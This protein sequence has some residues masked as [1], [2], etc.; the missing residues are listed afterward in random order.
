MFS[1]CSLLT[2][3]N[4]LQNFNVSKCNH[5]NEMFSGCSSLSDK[6]VLEKNG[7]FQIVMIL[8]ECS[9]VVGHYLV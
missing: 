8:E 5:F 7:M 9:L 6:K 4:P 1:G 2:D 3:I